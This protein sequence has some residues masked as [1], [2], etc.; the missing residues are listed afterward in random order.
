[1]GQFT[2][3][4]RGGQEQQGFVPAR[5]MS[6]A[7]FVENESEDTFDVGLWYYFSEVKA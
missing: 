7:I 2:A 5:G 1:M 3:A 6:M 4:I